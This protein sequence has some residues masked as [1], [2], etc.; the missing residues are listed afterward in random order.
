MRPVSLTSTPT[1][2]DVSVSEADA[3][4]HQ[5]PESDEEMQLLRAEVARLK[6]ENARLVQLE[7]RRRADE[8]RRSTRLEVSEGGCVMFNVR[9]HSR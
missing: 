8:K 9:R 7:E 5:A 6:V 2:V 3:N 4:I 1:L